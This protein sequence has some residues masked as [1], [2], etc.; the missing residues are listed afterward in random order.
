[1]THTTPYTDYGTQFAEIYDDLF[2]REHI[3]DAD[4]SWLAEHIPPGSPHILE[5]G[6]GTGRVALPLWETLTRRGDTPMFVGI[7]ISREMLNQL[8]TK[9]PHAHIDR[10]QGDIAHE[11]LGS[12]GYDTILCL[13]ATISMLTDHTAQQD[14]FR[15]AA[16]A[17]KPGGHLIVETHNSALIQALN[18]SGAGAYAVPYPGGQRMLVTFSELNGNQ[19]TVNH[20][21]INNGV[22][23][24]GNESSSV[25]TLAELDTYATEAGLTPVTH[26]SG[27]SGNPLQDHDATVCATYIKPHNS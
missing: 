3:T 6:V 13:C 23:T 24:F 27:L 26:T 7:D 20:C 21:W 25:T 4:T 14:T 22:A 16:K 10:R 18:P 19:W 2:P 5:L 1:M 9:D 17:L 8:A 12:N 15:A 11:D